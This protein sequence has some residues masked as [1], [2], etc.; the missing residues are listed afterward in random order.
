MANLVT[1]SPILFK[2]QNRRF[3]GSKRPAT[4]ALQPDKE[5]FLIMN[6]LS[7]RAPEGVRAGSVG[8][9]HSCISSSG[10]KPPVDIDGLEDLLL[11]TFSPEVAF[12]SRSVNGRD[13]VC[14]DKMCQGRFVQ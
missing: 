12:S 1:R 11:A 7:S 4:V 2:S 13:I 9:W 10:P 5:H 14:G 3:C 6:I 8:W